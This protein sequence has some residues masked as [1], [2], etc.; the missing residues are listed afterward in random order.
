MEQEQARMGLE[1]PSELYVDAAYVSAGQLVQAQAEGRQIIG[2]AQRG[3]AKE[4][5]FGV[6]QFD[7]Q[8][9]QRQAMCPAGQ[10]STQRSRLEEEATGK[11]SYRFEWST[12]CR[13]CPLKVAVT[14][15]APGG[16]WM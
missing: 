2:P 5:R 6:E 11:V 3:L 8:V 13:T 7:V 1:K 15:Y 9:E 14:S 12:H 16:S 10:L 4:N